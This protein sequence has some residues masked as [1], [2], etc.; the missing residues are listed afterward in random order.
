LEF[1]TYKLDR[2]TLALL[3]RMSI[4]PFND[5]LSIKVAFYIVYVY[6]PPL[7]FIIPFCPPF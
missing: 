3:L 5:I 2:V 6:N 1:F 4:E 7:I